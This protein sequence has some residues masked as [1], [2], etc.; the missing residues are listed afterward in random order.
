VE[1]GKFPL[2]FNEMSNT[3]DCPGVP[4]PEERLSATPWAKAWPQVAK[5]KAKIQ[6]NL[7]STARRYG[8]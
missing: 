7:N 4:D 6:K 5:V 8:I 2:E 3:T 1:S